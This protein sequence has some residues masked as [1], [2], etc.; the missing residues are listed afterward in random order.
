MKNFVL[1]L[2]V[3]LYNS[4]LLNAQDKPAALTRGES[5]SVSENLIKFEIGTPATF[6][7]SYEKK[8]NQNISLHSMLGSWVYGG[9]GAGAQFVYGV[10]PYYV[11]VPQFTLQSRFYHNLSKRAALDK[12]IKYNAANYIGFSSRFYHL[13]VFY[14]NSDSIQ[15]GSA[16]LDLMLSYGLQRTFFKRVNWDMAIEPGIEFYDGQ[17]EFFIGIKLQLGFV[18]F[19]N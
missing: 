11:I 4:F 1:F 17:A 13:G 2:V 3:I 10:S 18:V 8:L 9:G 15:K 7:I 12:N 16:V 6:G 19:S 14:S 5:A